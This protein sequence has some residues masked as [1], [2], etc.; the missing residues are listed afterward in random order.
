MPNEEDEEIIED[1]DTEDIA[2]P[3]QEATTE[4]EE[5]KAP[6]MPSAKPPPIRIP[7][8]KYVQIQFRIDA[9]TAARLGSRAAADGR[10]RSNFIRWIIE[11]FIRDNK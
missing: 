5:E 3:E 1:E 7:G 6:P 8:R 2:E 9:D 4:A 10:T 11:S